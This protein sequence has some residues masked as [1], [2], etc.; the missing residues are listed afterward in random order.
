M[1]S[2][3]TLVEVDTL[4]IGMGEALARYQEEVAAHLGEQPG[5]R[6]LLVMAN[7]D[8]R[9][10]IITLWDSEADALAG[11]QEG[12]FYEQALARFVTVFRQPPGRDHYEVLVADVPSVPAT[13]TGG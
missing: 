3:I 13:A 8:G 12:G 4:R 6:G 11:T 9:G 7:P 5:Y 2:R 1:H 10:M